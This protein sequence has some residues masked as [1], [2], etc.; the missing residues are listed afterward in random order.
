MP[1]AEESKPQEKVIALGPNPNPWFKG[2]VVEVNV[3]PDITREQVHEALDRIL[4]LSGC[5]ACGL[6]GFD[7]H[8]LGGDPEIFQSFREIE[9]VQDVKVVSKLAA[10]AQEL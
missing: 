10:V 7:V 2:N 6:L 3:R 9:G 4:T 1:K 8:I 5:L